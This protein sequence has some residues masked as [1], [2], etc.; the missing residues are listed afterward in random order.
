MGTPQDS[1]SETMQ[2]DVTSWQSGMR[3]VF[4]KDL[5]RGRVAQRAA[6]LLFLGLLMVLAVSVLHGV[7]TLHA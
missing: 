7:H 1:A 3:R 2:P 4:H 6:I 5:M